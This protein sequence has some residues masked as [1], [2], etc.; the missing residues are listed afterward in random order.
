MKDSCWQYGT[1]GKGHPR[2]PEV[3]LQGCSKAICRHVQSAIL[4]GCRDMML[5][6]EAEVPPTTIQHDISAFLKDGFLG[7][8]KNYDTDPLL[9]TP[10]GH[11]WPG[12]T[13]LQAL[14]DMAIPLFIV[15]ATVCRYVGD[16]NFNPKERLEEVLKFRG[17]GQLEQIEQTYLPVLSQ[18]PATLSESC[19]KEKLYQDF[20]KIVGSIV[21]LA[22]PFSATSWAILLDMRRDTIVLRLRPLQS[23]LRVPV[24]HEAPVRTLHLSFS[25]FLLSE[26]VQH[27]PFGVDGPATHH[28]LLM[29]CLEL[30]SGSN[31]LRE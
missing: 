5:H 7:I 10:L 16:P 14:V 15:A 13:I 8:R 12:D 23:V 3:L 4:P 26:K 22:E 17:M 31:G 2:Y 11:D 25:E 30:L 1:Y 27:Q 20:R 24:D 19:D 28:M 18:L 29:K 21:T 6:D 9:G